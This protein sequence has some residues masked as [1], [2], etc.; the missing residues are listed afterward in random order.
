M[1]IHHINTHVFPVPDI[2]ATLTRP[3]KRRQRVHDFLIGAL[4]KIFIIIKK[5]GRSP[6]SYK[7]L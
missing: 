7:N 6:C 2:F 3:M 5:P 1:F 4:N